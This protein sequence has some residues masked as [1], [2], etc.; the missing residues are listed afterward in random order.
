MKEQLVAQLKTQITDL[1]R[2]IEFLQGPAESANSCHC[3]TNPIGK[4]L[5]KT[6]VYGKMNQPQGFSSDKNVRI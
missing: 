6:N 3:S 2:F 4:P 5:S 1:E